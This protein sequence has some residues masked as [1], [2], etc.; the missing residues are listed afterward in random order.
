[1]YFDV[2]LTVYLSVT[3]ETG[4]LNAPDGHLQSVTIPYAV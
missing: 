2:L 3:L 4:Q 1:M